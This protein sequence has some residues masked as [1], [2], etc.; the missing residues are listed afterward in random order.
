MQDN[1]RE[2]TEYILKVGIQGESVRG[3]HGAVLV[4]TNTNDVV[5]LLCD[6]F[7]PL[8]F[9][10]KLKEMLSEDGMHYMYIVHKST[11]ALHVSKIPR[12]V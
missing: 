9:S 7:S 11:D 8:E 12:G 2:L 10:S 4:D 1:S 6:E 3:S 5:Y